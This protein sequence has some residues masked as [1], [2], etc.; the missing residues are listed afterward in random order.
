M[1][2]SFGLFLIKARASDN[3]ISTVSNVA[4]EN[5]HNPHLTR[6]I[7][8]NRHHIEVVVDLQVCI[9]EQVIQDQ[10]CIG[11]FLELNGNAKT[12]SVR[13]IP[14]FC[15]TGHL[16]V[17]TNI[18]NFLDQDSLINLIRNLSDDNL[19]LATFELLDL[20][21]RADSN[22]SLTSFIGFLDLIATLDNGT[23]REIRSRKKLHEFVYLSRRMVNHIDHRIDDFSKV[24]RRYI[25]R[26]TS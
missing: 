6:G 19:L 18:V 13:L 4:R 16:I 11:I 17:D 14:N 10:I 21:L 26:V 15:N 7:I 2:A 3:D 23:G 5:R 9:L 20:C 25:C 8:V 22:P 24:M 12:I 1:E